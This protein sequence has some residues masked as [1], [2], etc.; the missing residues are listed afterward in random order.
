M[1]EYFLKCV[2]PNAALEALEKFSTQSKGSSK[3][4]MYA[5]VI[6]IKL[7]AMIEDREEIEFVSDQ[8]VSQKL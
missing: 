7:E 8:H 4:K 6:A 1:F 3:N 2:D 5:G